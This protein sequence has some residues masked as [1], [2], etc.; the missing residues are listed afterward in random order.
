[1]SEME[2]NAKSV[3]GRKLA[4]IPPELLVDNWLDAMEL[5]ARVA[6]ARSLYDPHWYNCGKQA[7]RLFVGKGIFFRAGQNLPPTI[8]T[9]NNKFF[10]MV[11][12]EEHAQK[13][14]ALGERAVAGLLTE[15]TPDGETVV[16]QATDIEP[17]QERPAVLAEE[18]HQD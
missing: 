16:V 1:M 6:Y 9:Q 8:G 18:L 7:E 10:L 11:R 17:D 5:L 2:Q 15:G 4:K 3:I 13:L 12:S 14:I